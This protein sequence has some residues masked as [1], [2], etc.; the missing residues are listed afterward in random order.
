MSRDAL[1]DE[2][3][4]VDLETTCFEKQTSDMQTDIIEIGIAHLDRTTLQVVNNSSIFV[5]PT[6]SVITPFCTQLNG[7][8]EATIDLQGVSLITAF[9]ELLQHHMSKFRTW[10]SWGN[11]DRK[12]MEDDCR[13]LGFSYPMA[14]RHINVKTLFAVLYDLDKEVGMD[15][16]LELLEMPLVGRHHSGKDDA[17]NIALILAHIMAKFRNPR[18]ASEGV[19]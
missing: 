6:R 7:V 12:K 18:L 4:V 2:I 13:A 16:A 3:L 11:F 9:N 19:I 14:P 10:A 15:K 17:R 1:S 5:K 8:D